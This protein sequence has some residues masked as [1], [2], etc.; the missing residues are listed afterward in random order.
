MVDCLTR[1]FSSFPNVIFTIGDTEFI[2]TPQQYLTIHA[3]ESNGYICYSVFYSSSLEDSSSNSLWILG[4][5]F[6]YRYYSIYD[7]VNNRIGLA[8][9][10]SYDGTK[11]VNSSLFPKSTTTTII[12]ESTTTTIIPE[13]T[14]TTIIT[15]STVS[16]LV[17][18]GANVYKLSFYFYF[19]LLLLMMFTN[20][21]S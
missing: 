17:T 1:S 3:D 7:I 5:Y 9:S 8:K 16:E 11:S 21:I 14:K 18:A 6:L 13:S 10:I 20:H 19:F 15:E 12:P 2:L 4:D